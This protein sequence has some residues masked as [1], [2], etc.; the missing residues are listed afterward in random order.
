MKRFFKHQT[1]RTF[2]STMNSEFGQ[3]FGLSL[4]ITIVGMPVF[5]KLIQWQCKQ[6]I[7]LQESR[8]LGKKSKD[9]KKK[10]YYVMLSCITLNQFKFLTPKSPAGRELDCGF[11][12]HRSGFRIQVKIISRKGNQAKYLFLSCAND[13]CQLTQIFII[14]LPN[15]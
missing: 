7:L 13:I 15:S 8:F 10:I 2:R 6:K 1:L 4:E 5:F 9:S 12:G 11:E 14:L 3:Q